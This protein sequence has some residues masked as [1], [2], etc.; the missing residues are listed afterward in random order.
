MPLQQGKLGSGGILGVHLLKLCQ[1]YYLN[2]LLDKV[3]S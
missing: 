1:K 3:V 2:S